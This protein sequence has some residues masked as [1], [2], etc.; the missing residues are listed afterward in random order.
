MK[1]DF[2]NLR[3]P[4]PKVTK[5]QVQL[6]IVQLHVPARRFGR[7]FQQQNYRGTDRKFAIK[8]DKNFI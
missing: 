2:Q 3:Y 1:N 4:Q 5:L 8:P 7:N 6:R